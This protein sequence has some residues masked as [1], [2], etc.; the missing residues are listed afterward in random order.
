MRWDWE[1]KRMGN[2]HPLLILTHLSQQQ[3][4]TPSGESFPTLIL[5][6]TCGF[7]ALLFTGL[8]KASSAVAKIHVWV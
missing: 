5:L 2:G 8:S 1:D 6:L 4:R 3:A 7:H